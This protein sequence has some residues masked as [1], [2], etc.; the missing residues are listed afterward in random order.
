MSELRIL[1]IED[2]TDI[3]EV[4]AYNLKREGY[5]VITA[6]NGKEGLKLAKNKNP[7]LIILDLMMPEIDG[8]EVCRLIRAD[9][10]TQSIP[11]IMVTAKD[12]EA[13]IVLG[14]GLGADDYVTKP[15]SPKT[16]VAR[17]KAVLRRMKSQSADKAD[18][19]IVRAGLEINSIKHQVK[20]DGEP[21]ELTATAFRLLQLLAAHPGKV[22]TR[23]HLLSRIIGENAVVVDRNVDV[24][25]QAIRKK[26]GPYRDWIETVRGVGYR[27]R[28]E[29]AA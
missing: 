6:Q 20:I 28:E 7:N 13:D 26:M 24:H 8:L 19:V 4:I 15:F 23:D 17:V 27:F 10:L 25:I 12:D 18:D 3:R 21:I 29:D 14:L 2:E 1:V 16:L 5:A 11:I 22:F 9:S